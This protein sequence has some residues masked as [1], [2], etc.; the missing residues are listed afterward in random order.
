MC[1][2][3]VAA[4]FV[5]LLQ[6]FQDSSEMT[7]STVL[8]L[9]MHWCLQMTWLGAVVWLS[10]SEFRWSRLFWCI[11]LITLEW[12]VRVIKWGVVRGLEFGFEHLSFSLGFALIAW[13]TLPL[14]RVCVSTRADYEPGWQKARIF[15][16]ASIL[17][18][19]G[20]IYFAGLNV[21]AI[22]PNQLKAL[23]LFSSVLIASWYWA[24]KGVRPWIVSVLVF[25]HYVVG[26]E[27]I[28]S[29]E[30]GGSLVF[31]EDIL[32]VFQ[33][34]VV[35]LAAI[36]I[37]GIGAA[38]HGDHI[39]RIRSSSAIAA[40]PRWIAAALVISLT[41]V[42]AVSP[43]FRVEVREV[44]LGRWNT[45][46]ELFQGSSGGFKSKSFNVSFEVYCSFEGNY[47][48]RNAFR[49]RIEQQKQ[50]LLQQ[51]TRELRH[52]SRTQLTSSTLHP[53][54]V[55]KT[56]WSV[57]KESRMKQFGFTS[58]HVEERE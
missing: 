2:C 1:L 32:L 34:G 37:V 47:F 41:A 45:Q 25:L 7:L 9:T 30:P 57:L 49:K 44:G 38:L 26:F 8:F 6:Q 16:L 3:A 27:F 20:L 36:S 54:T 58:F 40:P 55:R 51:F 48:Q 42:V 33:E 21:L 12:V 4:L 43:W 23:A 11:P 18:G 53:V 14:T 39:V 24:A 13:S 35:I 56:L 29:F 22:E 19:S 17:L 15:V 31:S 52:A 10:I 50:E 28:I 46:V 5:I